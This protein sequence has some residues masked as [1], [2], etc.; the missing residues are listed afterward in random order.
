MDARYYPRIVGKNVVLSKH[1]E[2]QRK[3]RRTVSTGHECEGGERKSS[4]VAHL[5]RGILGLCEQLTH[6]TETVVS[7]DQQHIKVDNDYRFLRRSKRHIIQELAREQ[8]AHEKTKVDRNGLKL[9]MP[10]LG[11]QLWSKRYQ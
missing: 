11:G 3:R 1:D 10:E 8:R 9:L 5:E 2:T 7:K 4:D 6:A